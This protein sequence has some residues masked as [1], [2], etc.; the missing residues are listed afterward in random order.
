MNAIAS[1][2]LPLAIEDIDAAW[3]TAALRTRY[4]E[5]T[6]RGVEVVDVRNGACTKIRLRLDRDEA[7]VRAGL[8]EL[9]ILKGGF[10]P[11]S[12]EIPGM[13]QEEARAYQHVA[14]ALG[15]PTPRCYFAEFDPEL[16]QSAILMEDLVASGATFGDPRVGAGYE[17]TAWRMEVLAAF[18]A[19]TWDTPE[20][21]AASRWGML[22]DYIVKTQKHAG[23]FVQPEVWRGLIES[24]RG[25]AVSNRFHDAAWLVD[26]IDRELVL[27]QQGPHCV[28]HGDGH[29]GNTYVAADGSPGFYDVIAHRGPPLAE[30][31][32]VLVCALDQA[33]RP[34]WERALIARY[35]DALAR[36]GVDPPSFD[37]AWFQYVAYL[38]RAY[39][40]FIINGTAFQP[41]AINTTY[42]A[43]ISAA[44]LENDVD[45]VLRAI[46]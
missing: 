44:M 27:S 22:D 34:R 14:P 46:G 13:L 32:Y 25:A 6:I 15:L 33:D 38:P 7:A 30:I 1:P 2:R 10:E 35:L 40:V 3:M 29:R 8:P 20:R 23:H 39:F 21:L 18:H 19:Q 45:G 4:P 16:K 42:T 12:R 17:E 24:P 31:S 28:V 36:H 11:H 9:M 43:R 37:E 41:E 26:A 5:V